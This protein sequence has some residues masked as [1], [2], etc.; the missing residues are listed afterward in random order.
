MKRIALWMSLS[1]T[2]LLI[3][4][5]ALPVNAYASVSQYSTTC[6]SVWVTGTTNQPYVTLM[7]QDMETGAYVVDSAYPASRGTFTI[8]VTFPA[9]EEGHRLSY[10]VLGS[11]S[12]DLWDTEAIF[13]L[14]NVACENNDVGLGHGVPNGFVLHTITCEV[15]VYNL[16]AGTPVT[17]ATI[18]AGQTWFINPVPAAGSD[19]NQWTEV[20][21]GGLI[22]GFIPTSCVGGK[23]SVT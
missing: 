18:R 15:P 12:P 22:N 16:P 17:G 19:G 10:V 4:S 23:V 20:F 8:E 14:E 7:V 3:A 9:F 6:S 2:F 21:A 13:S 1:I 5:S 11:P